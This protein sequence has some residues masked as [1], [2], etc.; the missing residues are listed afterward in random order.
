VADPTSHTYYSQRLRLHYLDWGNP[1]ADPLLLLHG[2]RD[3]AHNWDWVARRLHDRYHVIAPDFRGH[4]DSQWSRGSTYAPAEFVY[5][6]A[7]LV[8]QQGLAPVRVIGHSLGAIVGL[9]YAGIFPE[10]VLRLVVVDGT[11]DMAMHAAGPPPAPERLRSWVEAHRS[12][13]GRQPR[14]YGSLEE[15]FHRLQEANPHLTG[16]QARYLTVHGA[17][18]NE[19]GTYSWKFDNHVHAGHLL[20][21]PYAEV[22]EL[23][24]SITSPVLFLTGEESWHVPT[25][26]EPAL[27][28]SFRDARHVFVPDAGHWIHHDQL[29]RFL[30]LAEGFLE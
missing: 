12:I 26:D 5:D 18:Q 6:V 11:G 4:G 30:A 29:D 27:V 14:R 28:A 15:A 7:Q 22:L 24:A 23:W 19:D 9:R 8:R 2:S 20:D 25:L 21:L 3:H 17:T 1:E 16:E 13:A 10:E